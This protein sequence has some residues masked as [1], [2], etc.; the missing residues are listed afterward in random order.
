MALFIKFTP[1]PATPT[2]VA[3]VSSDKLKTVAT[4]ATVAVKERH[5]AHN[6]PCLEPLTGHRLSRQALTSS[7][8]WRPEPRAWLTDFG[9]L[10]TQGVFESLADEIVRLTA[11]NLPLQAKLLRLHVGLYSGPSW[12]G[13]VQRWQERVRYLVDV[14][15]K[16]LKESN[17][18]AAWEMNLLGFLSELQ[19]QQPDAPT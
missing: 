4:V 2:T 1:P 18:L 10:R 17:W 8:D 16:G 7:N 12:A 9:E 11:D 14:E 3:T 5:S 13:T 6:N 19:L 15:K